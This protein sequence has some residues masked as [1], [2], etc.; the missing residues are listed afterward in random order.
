MPQVVFQEHKF[1]YGG[2]QGSGTALYPLPVQDDL[3]ESGI[4]STFP[5]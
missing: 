4:F 2:K 1:M 5:L 3:E